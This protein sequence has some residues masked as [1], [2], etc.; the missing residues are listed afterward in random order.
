MGKKMPFYNIFVDWA[1]VE[2]D[3]RLQWAVE[4]ALNTIMRGEHLIV[5]ITNL[6]MRRSRLTF[7]SSCIIE[8]SDFAGLVV[9]GAS[10]IIFSPIVLSD[11]GFPL[12]E[13]SE[14]AVEL[15]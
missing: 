7:Q 4:R 2:Q 3:N 8:A 5:G 12:L 13:M 15:N 10:R 1:G 11:S 6:S 9:D 14:E